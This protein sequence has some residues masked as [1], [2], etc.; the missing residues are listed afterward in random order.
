MTRATVQ[1]YELMWVGLALVALATH[2]RS[3][4]ELRRERL[5][6][7]WSGENGLLNYLVSTDLYR[8]LIKFGVQTAFL[9]PGIFVLFS[10][11]A[12]P[13]AAGRSMIVIGWLMMGQI[14]LAALSL[15][16]RVR[17]AG[18]LERTRAL[19]TKTKQWDGHERRQPT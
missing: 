1:W 14:G 3:M 19:I 5:R 9:V 13:R 7:L 4:W 16:G 12:N 15:F 18:A 2:S 11:P 17:R 8:E 6:Q 10:A